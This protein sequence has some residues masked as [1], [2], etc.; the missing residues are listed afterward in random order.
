MLVTVLVIGLV[1]VV[2]V[3]GWWWKRRF[4]DCI[5]GTPSDLFGESTKRSPCPRDDKDVC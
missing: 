2:I 5:G 3:I 4:C 1:A